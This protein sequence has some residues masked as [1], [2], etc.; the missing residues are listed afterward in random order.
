MNVVCMRLDI[1]ERENTQ[2]QKAQEEE[3]E[4]KNNKAKKNGTNAMLYNIRKNIIERTH[5]IRKHIWFY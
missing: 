5:Q 4:N 2:R 3:S 1:T